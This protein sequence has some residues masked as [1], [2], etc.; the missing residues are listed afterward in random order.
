MRKVFHNPVRLECLE[1]RQLRDGDPVTPSNGIDLQFVS[2]FTDDAS[3]VVTQ[4]AEAFAQVPLQGGFKWF[5]GTMQTV[6]E[7]NGANASFALVDGWHVW[8]RDPVTNT[9]IRTGEPSEAN[10]RWMANYYETRTEMVVID[11]ENWQMDVRIHSKDA[12]DANV[13]RFKNIV[14]WIREEAPTLK[15]GIYSLFPVSDFYASI[16]YDLYAEIAADPVNGAW[17]RYTL[18]TTSNQFASLQ[19]ANVYLEGLAADVDYIF[20]AVYTHSNDVDL[21]VRYAKAS[22]L[23]GRRYGKPVIPF[24][25][26][27]YHQGGGSLVH[28]VITQSF[29]QVQL[30][31]VRAYGDGAIIWSDEYTPTDPNSPWIQNTISFINGNS[32]LQSV[33]VPNPFILNPLD[34]NEDDD[35]FGNTLISELQVL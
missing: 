24:L 34:G 8:P 3:P 16:Q 18:P 32:N 19:N 11:I 9:P 31:T 23:E 22:I 27:T 28:Q 14:R 30:E 10:T 7:N 17:H 6:L 29:W 26:P 12:V 2:N 15:V 1:A 35:Q 21:W 25:M 33:S 5:D 20:P 4:S 13:A